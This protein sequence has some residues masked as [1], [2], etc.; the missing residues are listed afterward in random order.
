LAGPLV[1]ALCDP[2]ERRRQANARH[3]LRTCVPAAV[4]L[5]CRGLVERLLAGPAEGCRAARASLAQF[6]AAAVPALYC[7]LLHARGTATQLTL[8]EALAAIGARLP[9]RGRV[10]LML[11]LAVAHGRAAEDSARQAI[12]GAVAMLRRLNERAARSEEAPAW[13]TCR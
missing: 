1:D 13:A 8:V 2:D 7:R 11:D 5:V 10:D 4:A 3:V 12:D 9:T 6:G